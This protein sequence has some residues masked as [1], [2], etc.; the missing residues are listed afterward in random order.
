MS[1][2][3][4]LF[5]PHGFSYAMSEYVI[6]VWP[7]GFSLSPLVFDDRQQYEVVMIRNEKY[8]SKVVRH[9]HISE[10]LVAAYPMYM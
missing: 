8:V 7:Y 3:V 6:L 4:I 1:E 10:C 2:Y 9:F 5:W